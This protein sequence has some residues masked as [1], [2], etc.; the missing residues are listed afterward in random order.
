LTLFQLT[1]SLNRLLRMNYRKRKKMK[2][3]LA[4]EIKAA[5]SEQDLEIDPGPEKRRLS[6]VSFRKK[7]LDQDNYIGGLKLLIDGLVDLELLHDDSPEFLELEK[8]EQRIDL[9]NPR[10]EISIA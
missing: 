1:P 5:L 2:E 8:L 3:S 7:L 4:W 9:S 10:T 6:V